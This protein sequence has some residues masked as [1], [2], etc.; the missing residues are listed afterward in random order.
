M[1]A[2]ANAS[3]F[4]SE[5]A[6]I[7]RSSVFSLDATFGNTL[8][9]AHRELCVLLVSL[10]NTFVS[11]SFLCLASVRFLWLVVVAILPHLQPGVSYIKIQW[12]RTSWR[13][14]LYMAALLVVLLAIR[15]FRRSQTLV[16]ARLCWAR[17]TSELKRRVAQLPPIQS[18]GF[19]LAY[20]GTRVFVDSS[21][22]ADAVDLACVSIAAAYAAKTV[23]R[24]ELAK[25]A[26]ILSRRVSPASSSAT[27]LCHL[28]QHS[29]YDSS[30][31]SS[32]SSSFLARTLIAAAWTRVKVTFQR[33]AFGSRETVDGSCSALVAA[34]GGFPR[35]T[36][37]PTPSP[38]S[39]RSSRMHP[40]S[41]V[42]GS[43]TARG[44]PPQV[45]HREAVPA[46]TL[47]LDRYDSDDETTEADTEAAWLHFY[48]AIVTLQVLLPP[49]LVLYSA[50]VRHMYHYFQ[51]LVEVQGVVLGSVA[52]TSLATYFYRLCEYAWGTVEAVEWLL[53]TLNDVV[54]LTMLSSALY[55]NSRFCVPVSHKLMAVGERLVYMLTGIVVVINPNRPP[56]PS[57]SSC[58][59][60][61]SFSPGAARRSSP[62]RKT[63]SYGS[64]NRNKYKE[65]GRSSSSKRLAT[66][67]SSSSSSLGTLSSYWRRGLAVLSPRSLISS[68]ERLARP[69]IE[70]IMM[71]LPASILKMVLV[72]PDA[73]VPIIYS[74][75]SLRK[76][77]EWRRRRSFNGHE[78]EQE[79]EAYNNSGIEYWLCYF[80]GRAMFLVLGR[81][82][83]KSPI[84]L[85]LFGANGS[86]RVYLLS[87]IVLQLIAIEVR[88]VPTMLLRG[89]WML[90][91]GG[92]WLGGL[93]VRRCTRRGGT[94]AGTGTINNGSADGGSVA[95]AGAV[96]AHN[97]ADNN[98]GDTAAAAGAGRRPSTT[99]AADH[100]ESKCSS[101]PNVIE[102]LNVVKATDRNVMLVSGMSTDGGGDAGSARSDATKASLIPSAR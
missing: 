65:R 47:V 64:S 76:W 86:P 31:F 68:L 82:L 30:S 3:Q 27:D 95:T 39:K 69:V 48:V 92:S 46:T 93:L 14:R 4:L 58:V 45:G 52:A 91:E 41:H 35:S 80:T 74:T 54:K 79:R 18:A 17:G 15:R 2:V 26:F 7:H 75:R 88:V 57:S 83:L 96:G 20:A 32:F 62:R 85:M 25:S 90:L 89:F 81:L 29:G 71:V 59:V 24:R 100:E 60:A 66:V 51:F 42:K 6:E 10:Y 63:G 5:S 19:I 55:G 98:G 70:M 84:I 21:L 49:L 36:G 11:F 8:F 22:A 53:H 38:S 94:V 40:D 28:E 37:S 99:E 1:A 101:S 72:F 16:R 67:G 61:P 97:R 77:E 44:R 23:W 9:E 56:T 33:A 50:A 13:T 78:E 34:A 43:A 73:V 102:A 12:E 87:I